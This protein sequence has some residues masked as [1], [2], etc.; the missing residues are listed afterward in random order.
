MMAFTGQKIKGSRVFTP[1][2][3]ENRKKIPSST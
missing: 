3:I 1:E 2:K